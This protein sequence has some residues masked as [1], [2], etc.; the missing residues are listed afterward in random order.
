MTAVITCFKIGLYHHFNE[1]GR[2]EQLDH[3]VY[4]E[5]EEVLRECT[6][7]YFPQAAGPTMTMASCMFT[8]APDGHFIIDLHPQYPQVSYASA[9]TGHG[10][11]FASVIGEIMAAGRSVTELREDISKKLEKFVTAPEVTVIVN[12]SR[13]RIVYTIG[14]VNN[15]GPFILAPRMTV[16]QALSQVGGFAEW[17]NTKK[18]LII[19]REGGKEVRI[20]FNYE[21]FIDGDNVEQN[22]LLR[23]NDTI[24]VP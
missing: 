5:D 24:V 6:S 2:P 17:A 9:C 23:P 13:S 3:D 8:N 12:Q 14:K 1:T 22:I 7:K 15:P 19:R 4:W 10:Y 18:V 16:L 21:D 11:K 20:P